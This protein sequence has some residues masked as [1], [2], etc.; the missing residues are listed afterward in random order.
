MQCSVSKD[1]TETACTDN[2][3]CRPPSGWRNV[4]ARLC[5]AYVL[6]FSFTP[7]GL[8][9][10]VDNCNGVHRNQWGKADTQYTV[11]NVTQLAYIGVYVKSTAYT[12]N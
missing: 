3:T 12:T 5:A 6:P 4:G 7:L 11:Q 1:Q 8:C 10:H 9:R 2:V